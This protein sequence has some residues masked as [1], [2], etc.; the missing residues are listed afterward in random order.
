LVTIAELLSRGLRYLEGTSPS[1][2][3]DSEILL[4]HALACPRSHL[5]AHPEEVVPRTLA[6]RYARQLCQRRK[7]VPIAYLTGEREFWSLRLRVDP[8]TL[9]PRPET[10][11]L[12]ALALSF[13][14]S[15]A[16][17]RVADLGTGS[18]AIA[19]AV[20]TERPYCEVV[21]VDSS[22]N[23]LA[24]ARQNAKDHDVRNISFLASDWFKALH[25]ESFDLVLANPPYIADGDPRL[26]A[27]VLDYE[28]FQALIA[29]ETGFEAL[30]RIAEDALCHLAAGGY[31]IMEHG[32]GQSARL[33]EFLGSLGYH[34]VASHH[35]LNGHDR[36][37]Q[38]Q[39]IRN[40]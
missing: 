6:W 3:L 33:V 26:E 2:R 36:I 23:A 17:W 13:I 18:G 8:A 37:I 4:R 12:V 21:A 29:G 35:D 25:G 30:E 20:A 39:I 15:N 38:G 27:E 22:A 1:P 7:G 10:E 14:P 31:L 9:I 40:R 24:V 16:E 28:P 19:L 5:I 34:S 11:D 32:P